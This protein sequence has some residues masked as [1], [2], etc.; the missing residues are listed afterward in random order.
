MANN[1]GYTARQLTGRNVYHIHE[2]NQ[3]IYYDG[4][5]KTGYIITNQYVSKFSSWQMRLPLCIML[6]AVLILFNL[7]PFLSIGIAIV[8]YVVATILFHKLFLNN[9]P[10]KSNF[11]KPESKGFLRDIASRYPTNILNIF[12]V[13]FII[14]AIAMIVNMFATN[15]TGDAKTVTIVFSSIAIVAAVIMGLIIRVKQK[16]NL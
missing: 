9:L 11:E 8:A 14:L 5:S 7:N 4:F 12:F 16:E 2:K 13:M 6:G 3:T 10:I 1:S 15:V